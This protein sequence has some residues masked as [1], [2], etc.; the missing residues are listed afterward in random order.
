MSDLHL[1]DIAT[2]FSD[3]LE[4]RRVGV[5]LDLNINIVDAIINNNKGNVQEV[6]YQML[7]KWMNGQYDRKQADVKLWNTL[8][9]PRVNLSMIVYDVLGQTKGMQ[10]VCNFF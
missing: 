8:T 3:G 9:D 10:N 6:A 5:H 2:H 1:F 4:L 7:R